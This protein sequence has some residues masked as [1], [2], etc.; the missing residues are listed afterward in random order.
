[1][2]KCDIGHLTTPVVKQAPSHTADHLFEAGLPI[3]VALRPIRQVN[4]NS[5]NLPLTGGTCLA[6][7]SEAER[8]SPVLATTKPL[9][10]SAVRWQDSRITFCI[11]YVL[12]FVFIVYLYCS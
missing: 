2:Q 5:L 3:K 11:S 12:Y 1:M 4:A 10:V 7:S 8:L 9:K 6:P